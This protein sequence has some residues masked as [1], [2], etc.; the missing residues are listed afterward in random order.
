M[1]RKETTGRFLAL[2]TKCDNKHDTMD[3]TLQII[4]DIFNDF[5]SRVC[6]NCKWYILDTYFDM[7]SFDCMANDKGQTVVS[8]PPK[9]FGCNKFIR[10]E[11]K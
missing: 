7:N 6:E 9:D 3:L 8:F 10:K 11:I 2:A 5:E 1:T 4:E